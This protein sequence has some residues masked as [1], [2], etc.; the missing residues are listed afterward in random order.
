M[1]EPEDLLTVALGSRSYDIVIGSGLLAETGERLR[2]LLPGGQIAIVSNSTVA[3]LYLQSVQNSLQEAGF[4]SLPI[5][6]P[7]GEMYKDWQHLQTIFDALIT[8]RYERSSALLALGGGVVGDMTGYAAA[9]F[10]RGVSYV[11]LPTTLLAQVDSSVGGKTGINHALGKNLIGAFYQ[12]KTVLIDSDTLATLPERQLR[13]GLAEVIKYGLLWDA[14]FFAE[15]EGRQREILRLQPAA[16]RLIIQRSCAIKAAI[17]GQ[18]EREGEQGQRALLNLGHTFGHAIETLTG[19]TQLLHGE[20]VAIGMV[21]AAEL[22]V[23]LELAPAE[24]LQRT[25]ALL[26]SY[27]LPIQAPAFPVEAYLEAMARDKKVQDG[28]LRFVVVQDIGRATLRKGVPI[29]AIRQAISRHTQ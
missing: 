27:G 20:A 21:M 22:S 19:Y 12:P 2:R 16:I 11:Q 5:I 28:S 3:P 18:D 1:K 4:Q 15:L 23:L 8:H 13:A 29:E 17:V 7:D 24:S 26:Q 6:L 25:C 9:S 10:L 14:S